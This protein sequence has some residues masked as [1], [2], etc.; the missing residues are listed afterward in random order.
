MADMTAT[1]GRPPVEVIF[2]ENTGAAIT[3]AAIAQ[4]SA[5]AA[6]AAAGVGEYASTALGLAGTSLGETF[7]V[8][9]GDGTGQVYRHDAGPVAT[10]LQSFL[11][12]PAGEGAAA[13]LGATGGNVEQ[14]LTAA[15]DGIDRIDNVAPAP[16]YA[17]WEPAA[18]PNANTYFD[19]TDGDADDLYALWETFRAAYPTRITREQFGTD[20]SGTYPLWVYTIAPVRE[21]RRK[22]LLN[23]GSHGIEIAGMLGVLRAMM[24]FMGDDAR[25]DERARWLNDYCTVMIV[26]ALNPWGL[27]QSPRDRNNVNFVDLNRNND[28][29]WD[30]FVNPSEPGFGT[31][32][33]APFSEAETAALFALIADHPDIYRIADVHGFT[34]NTGGIVGLIF[35]PVWYLD[36]CRKRWSSFLSAYAGS[37]GDVSTQDSATDPNVSNSLGTRG[38]E[39][40]TAEYIPLPD[41][42]VPYSEDD[43]TRSVRFHGNLILELANGEAPQYLKRSQPFCRVYYY[44]IKDP[45]PT[46]E[47][48]GAALYEVDVFIPTCPGFLIFQGEITFRGPTNTAARFNVKPNIGQ[49]AAYPSDFRQSVGAYNYQ[50]LADVPAISGVQAYATIPF[51]V[52]MPVREGYTVRVG[53]KTWASVGGCRLFGGMGVLTFIPSDT[54]G[55]IFKLF[56][57]HTVTNAWTERA[58]NVLP[59]LT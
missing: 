59:I 51:H 3:A 17:L 49:D 31:K 4:S 13:L 44:T 8:D 5:Q 55:D 50:R 26:P 47:T 42:V 16:G 2:G 34:V 46:D 9:Q 57:P 20:E 23:C 1:I 52:G 14:R 27:S 56:M 40:V 21:S 45:V 30:A 12:N 36:S 32:G 54:G 29:R 6:L 48:A 53:L 58:P 43:M 11:I 35:P 39:C 18:E 19:T 7:W 41:P 25:K 37:D 10:A 24:Q 28:F 38:F 22:I 15:D 33:T